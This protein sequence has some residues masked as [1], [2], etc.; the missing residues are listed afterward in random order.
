MWR[1]L[2][3]TIAACGTT[4]GS[5]VG[6]T[7]TEWR[8]EPRHRRASCFPNKLS[9]ADFRTASLV[10]KFRDGANIQT[11]NPCRAFVSLIFKEKRCTLFFE[12]WLSPRRQATH[13]RGIAN[14]ALPTPFKLK[15]ELPGP[16][17]PLLVVSAPFQTGPDADSL[18]TEERHFVLALGRNRDTRVAS[19]AASWYFRN[20]ENFWHIQALA[21]YKGVLHVFHNAPCYGADIDAIAA[22]AT[23]A[24]T[25]GLIRDTWS[26]ELHDEKDDFGERDEIDQTPTDPDKILSAWAASIK[27]AQTLYVPYFAEWP[28]EAWRLP[29]LS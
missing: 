25:N 21:A 8:E 4:C 27:A 26:V 9:G 29:R 23:D 15:A 7:H 12:I 10:P 14:M 3:A 6:E 24:V 28:A 11:Y 17:G 22:A 1:F 13:E 5:R 19:V 16:T 18:R 20:R 2:A